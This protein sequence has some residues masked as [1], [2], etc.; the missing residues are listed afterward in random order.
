MQIRIAASIFLSCKM[1]AA[2]ATDI[3]RAE[4]AIEILVGIIVSFVTAGPATGL[5]NLAGPA[6]QRREAVA[7]VISSPGRAVVLTVAT[8]GI[9]RAGR[10][11][12][13]IHLS[14]S[15]GSGRGIQWVGHALL[16]FD[17]NSRHQPPSDT[18]SST[19]FLRPP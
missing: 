14:V 10:I 6:T 13:G 4:A 11:R 19:V 1:I 8:G 17:F 3:T 12:G 16:P 18:T 15:G 7:A 5:G 9:R 2:A